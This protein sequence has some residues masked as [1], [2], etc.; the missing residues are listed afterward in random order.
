MERI[1]TDFDY[2]KYTRAIV[3][4]EGKSPLMLNRFPDK[5]KESLSSKVKFQAEGGK[6]KQTDE[7]LDAYEC[8]YL[9]DV[10][11]VPTPYLPADNMYACLVS[12]GRNIKEGKR[13]LSTAS[14]TTLGHRL[15][16]LTHEIIIESEHGWA[17]D[18]RRVVNP[19]TNG[20]IIKIRPVF[21]YWKMT[22]EIGVDL[23]QLSEELLKRL[24]VIAG[25]NEGLGE[26]R[27]NRK[28]RFGAFVPIQIEFMDAF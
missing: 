11:G 3:T 21:P 27:I 22:F 12:A 5:A 26:F 24:L 2:P 6:L 13:N 8:L 23:N 14:T 15:I 16:I 10:N 20:S 17:I 28:G 19:T 7:Y 9:T 4:I 1:I 18:S 25:N